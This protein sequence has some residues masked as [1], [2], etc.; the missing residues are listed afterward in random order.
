MEPE[1]VHISTR[2]ANEFALTLP[3]KDTYVMQGLTANKSLDIYHLILAPTHACNLRCKHCYLNDHDAN[4]L[5]KDVALRLVDE[6]SEIVLEERGP[7]CGIFHVKGGEPFLVPYLGS[8]MDRLA[9]LQS[10]RLMMTTN[11]TFTS[12]RVLNRLIACNEALAGRVTMIVSL[13]GA[14]ATTH[15]AL[16]GAGQFAVTM[17][18]LRSICATGINTHLNCVLYEANLN[19]VP[20]YI[21]LAKDL[22]VAQINFL[23]LVPRGYGNTLR[24][25]QSSHLRLHAELQSIYD[26]G[27]KATRQ[28]L[29]GSLSY[30]VDQDRNQGIPAAHECVAAY[31]GLFYITPEGNVYTCPNLIGTEHSLGNVHKTSLRVLCDR[32]PNLYRDVRGVS[33]SDDRYICTGERVLYEKKPD[34]G[35][36]ASLRSLQQALSGHSEE[37]EDASAMAYCVSRNF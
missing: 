3:Q 23:P 32:L 17:S 28:L 19:E 18:F 1:L 20:A 8:I 31:R 25:Q 2:S 10:L 34:I 35:N 14:S 12:T 36:L 11:G 27:D 30:I 6:W 4:L 13:D 5:P 16:R 15:D 24:P 33:A 21:N 7:F 29:S 9:E 22:R 37:K 26:S